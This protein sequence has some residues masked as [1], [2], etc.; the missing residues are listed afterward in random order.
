[1]QKKTYPQLTFA[2]VHERGMRKDGK[3]LSS[4]AKAYW[5]EMWAGDTIHED[6]RCGKLASLVVVLETIFP[7]SMEANN[8]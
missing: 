3:L 1:M 4:K 5:T 7:Y 8:K 2:P 6:Y